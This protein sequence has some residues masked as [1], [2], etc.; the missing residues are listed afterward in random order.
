MSTPVIRLHEVRTPAVEVEVVPGDVRTYD[1]FEIARRLEPRM[2]PDLSLAQTIGVLRE[3]LGLSEEVAD[4]KVL[5]LN[6]QLLEFVAET[7][8]SKGGPPA[9]R[10]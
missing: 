4:Y 8:R 3:V 10:S 6:Q 7:L 5:W 1:P 9:P 2:V